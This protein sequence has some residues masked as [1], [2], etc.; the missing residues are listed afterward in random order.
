MKCRRCIDHYT[1]EMRRL[2]AIHDLKGKNEG[3]SHAFIK[4]QMC[5]LMREIGRNWS[6]TWDERSLE[7]EAYVKG[8]CKVDVVATIGDATIAV[9]CGTTNHKKI[10]ALKERFDIV[11][12]VPYC[13]NGDLYHLDRDELGHQIMVINIFKELRK[14]GIPIERGKPF[15]LEDG[16]CSLPSGRD[17]YPHEAI[18]LASHHKK[19]RQTEQP[20]GENKEKSA[21]T[22]S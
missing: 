17:G 18:E 16:E 20:V 7:T 12:H 8:I 1:M 21:D 22:V 14:E 13:Y 10:G 9:E 19:E 3:F 6:E 4:S 2:E 5:E 15:C 11:L